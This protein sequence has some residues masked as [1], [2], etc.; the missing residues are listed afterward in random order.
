MAENYQREF[1]QIAEGVGLSA[2]EIAAQIEFM[3]K[4][5]TGTQR[6]IVE[7]ARKGLA[8]CRNH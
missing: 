2:R 5:S 1:R 4:Q 3:A 8:Q 7:S 6:S